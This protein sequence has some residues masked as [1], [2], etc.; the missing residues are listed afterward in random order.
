MTRGHAPVSHADQIGDN[1]TDAFGNDAGGYAQGQGYGPYDLA[2]GDSIHI[3]LAEAV[4]G[5]SREQCIDIGKKWFDNAAPFR[6]PNGTTTND[7]NQFKNT[8]VKTGIDSLYR[9]FRHARQN[10]GSNY[11]IPQP[12]PPPNI[13]EVKS[14]GDRISLSWSDNAVSWPGFNGYKIYRAIAKPDTFYTEIFSCDRANVVHAFDDVTARRGFDYYYY[15]VSK[16]D[17]SKNDYNPGV[18]LVSSKFYTMTNEPAYLRRPASD[19]LADIRV[20]PNPYDIRSRNLQFGGDAPDRIA[21]FGLPPQCTI[22][23]YTE[24]GDLIQ[25][26]E[27]TDGSGDELWDSLTSSRQVIVS[28][29]YIVVFETPDGNSTHRK[30]IVI[31]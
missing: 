28:G 11:A 16:D 8:W 1:F 12:P 30:F 21:F 17:G 19:N 25:T 9:T 13:F 24:R 23:I 2:P 26:L 3:V 14:G 20:V 10:F 5:L 6:L 18:P 15:I 4:D 29:L 31:R 27:H 22:K 7:R